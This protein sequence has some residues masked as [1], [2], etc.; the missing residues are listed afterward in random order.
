MD[1]LI[2]GGGITGAGVAL[3][4]AASGLNM[5]PRSFSLNLEVST[6]IADPAMVDALADVARTYESICTEL[7]YGPWSARPQRH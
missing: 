4:A 7:R 3:Q 6:F 1:L 5:D 2:I